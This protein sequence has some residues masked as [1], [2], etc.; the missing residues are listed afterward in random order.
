MT[1][2]HANVICAFVGH[3]I[4][5]GSSSAVP[6]DGDD[7]NGEMR[8][9]KAYLKQN[10]YF[11]N[12]AENSEGGV[13]QDGAGCQINTNFLLTIL[14]ALRQHAVSDRMRLVKLL[15]A[16]NSSNTTACQ[17]LG[18]DDI[19]IQ[20]SKSLNSFRACIDIMVDIG[21]RCLLRLPTNHSSRSICGMIVRGLVESFVGSDNFSDKPLSYLAP[22]GTDSSLRSVIDP[23]RY[24]DA[25]ANASSNPLLD[26]SRSRR[27]NITGNQSI[28]QLIGLQ[29]PKDVQDIVKA[30]FMRDLVDMQVSGCGYGD[31]L[32]WCHLPISPEP[33]LVDY[34]SNFPNNLSSVDDVAPQ[35]HWVIDEDGT[36]LDHAHL[37][38]R[39][40]FSLLV[41]LRKWHSPWT[42]ES[43]LSFSIPHRRAISTL[44]LCAHRYGVPGESTCLA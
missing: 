13:P 39:Y 33:L 34:I 30:L 31:F 5:R 1:R 7:S 27:A 20:I 32:V 35:N 40:D 19:S 4:N 24:A 17:E 25:V 18:D 23:L 15:D 21:E 28:E 3:E 43:H 42:P 6:A 36:E 12:N 2:E 29:P 9:G 41:F 14:S 44:A 11:L 38:A 26:P 37:S 8:S 10:I 16:L 22:E